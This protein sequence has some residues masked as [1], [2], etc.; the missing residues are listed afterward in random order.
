[1]NEGQRFGRA[2]EDFAA[3]VLQLYGYEILVRN[4]RC[5][6]GEIDIV[7]QRE[8][9]LFFVEV[10]TRRDA[11]FGLPC[12]AV[13]LQKQRHMRKA[14]AMFLSEHRGP[15]EAYS[16]QVVEIGFHQIENAF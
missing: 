12:E 14:A 10:K 6:E 4:Y 1:M 5:R 15:W 11:A 7:A 8:R 3:E 13:N 16:F 2:G 9:E